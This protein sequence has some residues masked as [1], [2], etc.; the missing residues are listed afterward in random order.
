M[1][2]NYSALENKA[3]ELEE[4]LSN[5][6][7]ENDWDSIGDIISS[8]PKDAWYGKSVDVFY[9]CCARIIREKDKERALKIPGTIR[10][11]YQEKQSSDAALADRISNSFK[12]Y[13]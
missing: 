9:E 3:K 13:Y 12:P 11:I 7:K 8:I 4:S 10:Y 1:E 6:L 2:W 5:L